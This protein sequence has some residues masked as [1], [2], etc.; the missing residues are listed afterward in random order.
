MGSSGVSSESPVA[1][2][3]ARVRSVHIYTLSDPRTGEVRYVGKAFN[4]KSRLRQHLKPRADQRRTPNTSW[5][6]SLRRAGVEPVLTVIETCGE[7]VWAERERHHI[8]AFRAAGVKLNN[9]ADGGNQPS[10]DRET[11]SRNAKRANAHQDWPIWQMMAFFARQR[12]R[13]A[14]NGGH[15]MV[16]KLTAM[17]ERLRSCQ[18][19][20]RDLFREYARKHFHG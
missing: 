3:S 5:L 8:A 11:R 19:A 4:V 10:C 15:A 12:I 7:D 1:R 18:G 9:L 2:P 14:K 20:E 16:D 6:V 13:S 17:I